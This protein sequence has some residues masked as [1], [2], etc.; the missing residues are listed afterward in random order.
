VFCFNCEDPSLSV[1]PQI[2]L[3]SPTSY[4]RSLHLQAPSAAQSV[5]SPRRPGSNTRADFLADS[6]YFLSSL[7]P[8]IILPIRYRPTQRSPTLK[9]P[10]SLSRSLISSGFRYQ[11]TLRLIHNKGNSGLPGCYA[12]STGKE[13]PM[14][15]GT[16]MSPSSG[17]NVQ[18]DWTLTV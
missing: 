5:F 16:V 2:K 3:P 15:R 17:P 14:F 7:P 1:I 18:E 11:Q 6:S 10:N 4:F 8:I 12:V 13:L 9:Q